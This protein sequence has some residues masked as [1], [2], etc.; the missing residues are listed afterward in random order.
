MKCSPEASSLQSG[1]DSYWSVGVEGLEFGDGGVRH[2]FR[3]WDDEF[4]GGHVGL[5]S[6][7]VPQ[8][9]APQSR[10]IWIS[11]FHSLKL[12]KFH[13]LCGKFMFSVKLLR[14]DTGEFHSLD[15]PGVGSIGRGG[16]LERQLHLLAVERGKIE[17]PLSANDQLPASGQGGDLHLS[18]FCGA[19][20]TR[21]ANPQSWRRVSLELG[22]MFEGNL[23]LG[24]AF[25]RDYRRRHSVRKAFFRRAAGVRHSH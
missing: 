12:F 5:A 1:Q 16:V 2:Q 19:A 25:K 21:T 24:P 10:D 20:A 6:S 9:Q 14:L 17:H 3:L 18:P 7:G 11:T 15:L 13:M 4:G 23:R 22:G 8:R